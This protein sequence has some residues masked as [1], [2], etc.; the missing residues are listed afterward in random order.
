[1]R[2]RTNEKGKNNVGTLLCCVLQ[3]KSD[4]EQR[5]I[6]IVNVLDISNRKLFSV[7]I[8]KTEKVERY[9]ICKRNRNGLDI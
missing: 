4:I 3:A 8:D 7:I 2:R 6:W 9:F 1:M 5:Y